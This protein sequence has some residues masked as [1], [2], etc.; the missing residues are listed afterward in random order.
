MVVKKHIAGVRI[1]S[2]HKRI[3]HEVKEK[4]VS[5]P[6]KKHHPFT[7]KVHEKHKI[8]HGTLLYMK[9]YGPKSHVVPVIVRES[10]KILIPAS[11]ISSIGGVGLQYLQD[12]IIMIVPLLILLPALNDMMGDYGTIVSSKFTTMLYM[13]DVNLKNYHKS[14][15]VHSL[16][17]VVFTVAFLSSLYIGTLSIAI[18][19]LKGNV[20]S[21]GLLWRVLMISVFSAMILISVIALI[22]IFLGIFIFKRGEDPN[23]FLIPITTSIA[24]LGSMTIF[25]ILIVLLF[26]I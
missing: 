4:L 8:S 14:R 24:D 25:S 15:A 23:N 5:L 21:T 17:L 22:S 1:V 19:Y 9:E 2:E 13:G 18:S 16:L 7:Y 11:L 10:I 26:G 20:I 12:K 6:R 3:P